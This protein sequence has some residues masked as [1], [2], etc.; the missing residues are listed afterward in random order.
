MWKSDIRKLVRYSV[1]G[2]GI[3]SF[4]QTSHFA[5][6]DDTTL[7]Q[8][9]HLAV[10]LIVGVFGSRT[11]S[12][13]HAIIIISKRRPMALYFWGRHQR[14]T[15]SAPIGY[16]AGQSCAVSCSIASIVWERT[17]DINLWSIDVYVS[18]CLS[19][20][21]TSQKCVCFVLGYDQ[22]YL[23]RAIG[24][25]SDTPC[26][27]SFSISVFPYRRVI[28]EIIHVRWAINHDNRLHYGSALIPAGE[29][30]FVSYCSHAL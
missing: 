16:R 2:I 27:D 25:S 1:Q 4:R 6:E 8:I 23:L 9:S 11:F 20:V 5:A 7:F 29:V 22:R 15:F 30:M 24:F 21:L 17:Q 12:V 19:V 3:L 13:Y 26:D 10:R 18:G 14:Q 28:A